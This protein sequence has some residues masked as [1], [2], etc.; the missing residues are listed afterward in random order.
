MRYTAQ[1]G[2]FP[3]V[4]DR[5]A[6]SDVRLGCFVTKPVNRL[7][8]R[9]RKA[10]LTHLLTK[11]PVSPVPKCPTVPRD[12]TSLL[13]AQSDFIVLKLVKAPS[14]PAEDRLRIHNVTKTARARVNQDSGPREKMTYLFRN[15]Q[16]IFK[17]Y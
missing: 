8:N 14:S 7:P 13:F 1:R 15:L 12:P 11:R 2:H 3:T 10:V 6:V 17:I 9:V 4:W 5:R 16:E